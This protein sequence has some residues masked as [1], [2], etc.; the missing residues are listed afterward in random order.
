[1]RYQNFTR[2]NAISQ[3]SF[4]SVALYIRV[5]NFS[6]ERK[7]G[8]GETWR[9]WSAKFLRP[10]RGQTRSGKR[11]P[12]GYTHHVRILRGCRNDSKYSR[13]LFGVERWSWE[14]WRWYLQKAN[15]ND[16]F[17]GRK[18]LKN[19]TAYPTS[20]TGTVTCWKWITL[21]ALRIEHYEF[22]LTIIF[23]I[24]NISHIVES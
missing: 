2:R 17:W 22:M 11:Q 20:S 6:L 7:S 10:F 12:T 24:S 23:L 3:Y 9:A 15:R 18:Y 1:M 5:F 13:K 14:M 19:L 4:I 21:F 16:F 8:V